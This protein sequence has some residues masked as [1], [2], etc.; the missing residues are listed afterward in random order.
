M[1]KCPNCNT[2][3]N[4]GQKFCFE[5]GTKIPQEKTCPQCGSV[6]PLQTK[7]CGECGFNFNAAAPTAGLAMGNENVIAG[8]VIGQKVAGD[9][10]SSKVMGN[11]IHN[12]VSDDTKSVNHCSVCGVHMTNDSGHTCPKCGKIVCTSHFIDKFLCCS[13]CAQ[14]LLAAEERTRTSKIELNSSEYVD[15]RDGNV[16]KTVKIGD[17]EWFA[18]NFRYESEESWAYDDDDSDVESF[19]RLYSWNAAINDAPEGWHLPSKE[20]YEQL[21]KFVESNGKNVAGKA[22]KSC[23]KEIWNEEGNGV[24]E[25]GFAAL[26]A[27][28]YDF[29]NGDEYQNKGEMADFWSSSEDGSLT[30]IDINL[31]AE[32]DEIRCCEKVNKKNRCSVRYVKNTAEYERKLQENLAR[33]GSFV[34][35]RDGEVYKTVKIGNQEWF[36]EN[37]RY[38][39]PKSKKNKEKIDAYGRLYKWAEVENLAP[40]GWHVP[41]V[42]EYRQLMSFVEKDSENTVEDALKSKIDWSDWHCYGYEDGVDEYGFNILPVLGSSGSVFWCSTDTD[43]DGDKCIYGMKVDD[44]VIEIDDYLDEDEYYSVRFIKNTDEYE[45]KAQLNAAEYERKLQEKLARLGSFVD[46]RDGEVY[47]TVKIGNQEWFAENYRYKSP[48]SKKNKEKIDAY[49]RLYKW[50]EV[51]NL[52][53]EGWHVP[54]VDDFRQLMSFVEKDSENTVEE[55]LKSKMDWSDL[56]HEDGVDEYGFNILPVLGRLGSVFWCSTDTDEDGDE[57]IYGMKVGMK[58]DEVIEIDHYLDEDEYYSIRFIKNTDEYENKSKF[59]KF[60]DVRDGQVYKTVKIGNQVWL[61]ENLR[62]ECYDGSYGYG[63]DEDN[64][65][66]Y[67]RLYTWKAAQEAVLEG[68]HIPT[69]EDVDELISYVSENTDTCP[70]DYDESDDA[71]GTVLKSVSG[72][73]KCDWTQEG[74]DEFGFSALPGGYVEKSS[75]TCVGEDARFWES[76]K[77]PSGAVYVFGMSSFSEGVFQDYFSKDGHYFSIRLVK[78]KK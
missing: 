19:G 41:T 33:F 47:K 36:A 45:K 37:Y 13:T 5:C 31:D 44:E 8:D 63:D 24:D 26:P 3:V 12:T 15:P 61:A 64:L 40:E 56:G 11:I 50:A 69:E 51:E 70:M 43:E 39:S 72:W 77:T 48:K 34:D 21:E 42:D 27:G 58:V 17:Q 65:E 49:G 18:E 75:L 6:L 55:A 57:C 53:P 60:K 20:E 28:Y 73:E 59:G 54:T 30:A 4:A 7:F 62:Y 46:P 16:Y 25:F 35:P 67:G 32:A 68:W 22:L 38:K 78:N 52:A 76:T 71:V 1:P 74:T 10:V 29:D 2:E 9:N 14:P 23:E 66:K